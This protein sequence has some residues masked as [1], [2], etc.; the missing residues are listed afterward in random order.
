MMLARI[1]RVALLPLWL[2]VVL[3]PGCM[4]PPATPTGT[5][6]NQPYNPGNGITNAPPP[7]PEGDWGQIPQE[8][9]GP[10]EL[11]SSDFRPTFRLRNDGPDRTETIRVSEIGRAHV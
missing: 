3:A 9:R 1:P 11:P 2:L 4:P 8:L 6:P 7:V 10:G 5:T